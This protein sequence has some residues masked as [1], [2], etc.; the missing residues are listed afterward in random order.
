MMMMMITIIVE[1]S[2][3]CLLPVTPAQ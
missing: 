2:R 3:I 1:H